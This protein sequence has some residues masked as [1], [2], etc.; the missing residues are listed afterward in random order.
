M[1]TKKRFTF[2]DAKQEIKELKEEINSYKVKFDDNVFTNEEV[3]TLKVYRTGF[4][5]CGLLNIVLLIALFSG[6]SKDMPMDMPM[7]TPMEMPM[8]MPMEK[9][10]MEM[11]MEMEK[12][13]TEM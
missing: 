4:W 5:I 3:K 6:S 11:D 8:D 1:A 9:D 13:S 12:D 10:S 7:E 2:A